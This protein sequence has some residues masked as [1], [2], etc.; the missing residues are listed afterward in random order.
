MV[1]YLYIRECSHCGLQYFGKTNGVNPYYTGGGLYWNRHLKYHDAD[2]RQIKLFSFGSQEEATK[3]AVEFSF[4]NDIV[5]SELW[6]NL[7]VENALDGHPL[8]WLHSEETKSKI[9]HSLNNM[10]EENKNIRS[11]RLS[12]AG[13]KRV[14]SEQHKEKIRTLK[15]GKK[16]KPF[17]DKHKMNLGISAIGNKG[18][19]GQPLTEEHKLKIKQGNINFHVN[20]NTSKYDPLEDASS[21]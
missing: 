21:S 18:R 11:E 12:K 16:R 9:S 19:R 5:E 8:G 15:T 6:A 3:F 2:S 14:L 13:K 1:I 4:I 20:H 10:S 17:T 7:K